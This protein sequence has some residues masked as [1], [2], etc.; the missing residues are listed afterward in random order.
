VFE[1]RALR[2]ILR[3]KREELRRGWR[4]I[5]NEELPHL[6]SALNIIRSSESKIM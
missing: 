1:N 6:Y 3:P 4:R 5:H 2:R